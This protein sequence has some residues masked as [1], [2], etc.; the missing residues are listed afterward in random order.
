[1]SVE[2]SICPDIY[3]PAIAQDGLLTRLRIPGGVLETA[4]CLAIADLLT[5]TGLDD[6]QVTN[7]ANLQLRSLSQ[8][9]AP[10]VLTKLTDCGL[11]TRN[12]SIEGIRNLMLSP[13]AGIDPQEL[14]DV[15]P[16]AQAW[17]DYLDDHPELRIL[18]NKFSVGIDGGGRVSIVDRPN[19]ITLLA[20]SNCELDLYLGIGSRGSAPVSVGVRLGL[21]ECCQC[22]PRSLKVIEREL[23]Y[24]V[25]IHAGDQGYG[26]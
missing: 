25:E 22:W 4:Q 18:S 23:N 6:L 1:V 11:V 17:M 12:Q 14:I 5:A 7:R 15:R 26:M 9:L 24:W 13:T 2:R 3:H 16:L 20:V 8:D 19:D 21:A 10:A